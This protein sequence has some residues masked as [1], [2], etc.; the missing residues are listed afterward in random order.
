MSTFRRGK[1]RNVIVKEVQYADLSTEKITAA[2]LFDRMKNVVNLPQPLDFRALNC[3]GIYHNLGNKVLGLVSNYPDTA[4]GAGGDVFQL[5]ELSLRP[6]RH[7]Q[8]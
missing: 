8:R 6:V 4:V 3:S 5:V 1:L 2:V 7:C